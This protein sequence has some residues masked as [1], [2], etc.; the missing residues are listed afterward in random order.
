MR[1]VL[2]IDAA[3][4]ATEPSGVALVVERGR[5]WRCVALAPSYGELLSLAAGRPVAW[6]SCRPAGCLPDPAALV[7]ACARLAPGA[8]LA[9]VALDVP[10]ARGPIAARRA[11][12][13]A[14]SRAFGARGLGAHSPSRERPG[15]I[16]ALLRDGFAARGFSL[17]TGGAPTGRD[18]LEVFP[19]TAI[20]ALLGADYRVPY[21]ASRALRYWPGASAPERRA[22]LVAA[23]RRILRALARRIDGVRLVLP[24]APATT[25]GLKRYEDAL[26][27]LVCAWVGIEFLAGRATALGD[28]EAAVWTPASSIAL[29]PSAGARSGPRSRPAVRQRRAVFA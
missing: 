4:T 26:D 2:G 24:P 3:W 11:A 19:H 21:K 1:A 14:V 18:L 13:D 15:P 28:G 29:A 5:R 6:P 23:W 7:D 22:R 17:A 25:S 27:A 20:L 8:A 12:D 10:L 9:A 16:S